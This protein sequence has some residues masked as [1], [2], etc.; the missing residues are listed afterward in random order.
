MR[1]H[2]DAYPFFYIISCGECNRADGK[3]AIKIGISE[4]KKPLERLHT[5]LRH[6]GPSLKI[7]LIKV[8]KG[9]HISSE[10][11]TRT[12]YTPD[13]KNYETQIKQSFNNGFFSSEP[14]DRNGTKYQNEWFFFKDLPRMFEIID[15]LDKGNF[16]QKAEAFIR[17]QVTRNFNLHKIA[18]ADAVADGTAIPKSKTPLKIYKPELNNVVMTEGSNKPK[19]NWKSHVKLMFGKKF[20]DVKGTMYNK[21]GKQAPYLL[22]DF[23]YDV[24]HKYL[25]PESESTA[26]GEGWRKGGN[27]F[28][29]IMPYLY[30]GSQKMGCPP[31][32]EYDPIVLSECPIR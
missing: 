25:I 19:A 13:F 4:S 20:S 30:G 27:I 31:G 9:V 14:L 11:R 28:G 26:I 23:T 5:Y 21:N 32:F 17:K 1:S 18:D 29:R 12:G 10:E 24:E 7:H 16:N 2:G 15:D 6:Y 8:F 22:T 3:R